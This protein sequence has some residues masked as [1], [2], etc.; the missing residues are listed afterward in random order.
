MEPISTEALEEIEAIQ[1]I[2]PEWFLASL[3]PVDDAASDDDEETAGP[4][5][6]AFEPDFLRPLDSDNE[7]EP[8]EAPKEEA[9]PS[10]GLSEPDYSSFTLRIPVGEDNPGSMYLDL[11]VFLPLDYP[12]ISCPLFEFGGSAL[13]FL[14]RARMDILDEELNSAFTPGDVVLFMWIESI[15]SLL[16]DAFPGGLAPP[17]NSAVSSPLSKP[18][19]A[20]K[21]NQAP[22]EA[23]GHTFSMDWAI[24]E[25]SVVQKSTFIGFAVSVKTPDEVRRA[26]QDLREDKDIARATH[27]IMAYRLVGSDGKVREDRDDDGEDG[28]SRFLAFMMAQAEV[29]NFLVVVVRFFGGT[30]LG[31]LRFR[32]IQTCGRDALVKAGAIPPSKK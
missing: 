16:S 31:P 20:S 7:E 10:Q 25:P 14:N 30:L 27:R 17:G 12:A 2:Y 29:S 23:S 28:A 15:R 18:E 22:L 6:G 8:A 13:P 3:A 4:S 32:L 21:A 5:S 1:S 19:R 26:M 24:T 11:H 9:G